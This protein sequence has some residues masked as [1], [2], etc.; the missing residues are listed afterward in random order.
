LNVSRQVPER[1]PKDATSEEAAFDVSDEAQNVADAENEPVADL[2]REEPAL[3]DSEQGAGAEE[4]AIE[5]E[6]ENARED[7]GAGALAGSHR[8]S[9]NAA[10]SSTQRKKNDT[11]R[12]KT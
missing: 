10:L 4:G 9:A 1:T 6:I 11:P 2:A 3:W 7:T 5:A 12:S 8:V